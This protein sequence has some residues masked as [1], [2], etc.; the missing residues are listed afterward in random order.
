MK[1]KDKLAI[2]DTSTITYGGV[3]MHVKYKPGV[4]NIL[5]VNFNGATKREIRPHPYFSGFLPVDCHQILIADPTL[6]ANKKF[7]AGW[8]LGTSKQNLPDVITSFCTTLAH[9]LGINRRV[10]MGGSSGG[11]AALL[12]SHRDPDSMAVA[13]CPQTNLEIYDNS[14]AKSFRQQGWPEST[15]HSNWGMHAPVNL[16]AL[17]SKNFLNRVIYIQSLEDLDHLKDHLIPF[18]SSLPICSFDRVMF[19]VGYWGIP[20]H[21]GSVPAAAFM[22]WVKAAVQ[23]SSWNREDIL[24]A[25]E[26]IQLQSKPNIE[27]HL[28][29][30]IDESKWKEADIQLADKLRDYTLSSS[31]IS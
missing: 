5:L 23:A 28:K 1:I 7:V 2:G 29:S 14:F 25:Y 26:L 10:Y 30:S 13:S 27:L 19:Q 15:E 18:S 16:C 11:F 21:S 8:Y 24:T 17:Y 22:P 20:G 6:E 4:R 9:E 12:Y 3:A 31:E